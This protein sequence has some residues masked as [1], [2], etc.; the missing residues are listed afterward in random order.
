MLALRRNTD[1][2]RSGQSRFLETPD[3]LL[4]FTRG[5]D[6]LC[7]FNLSK[8]CL[9][10][11]QPPQTTLLVSEGFTADGRLQPLGFAILSLVH[12]QNSDI[13]S[14]AVPAV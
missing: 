9:T 2:L 4:A 8:A 1:A 11:P 13:T 12:G 3:G 6:V 5:N 7:I 10:H 14:L